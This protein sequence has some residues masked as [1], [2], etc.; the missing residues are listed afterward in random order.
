M[1]C[2]QPSLK[3]L[4]RVKMNDSNKNVWGDKPHMFMESYRHEYLI[5]T[6][7]LGQTG[8]C[9]TTAIYDKD[10]CLCH[11]LFYT[12][13]EEDASYKHQVLLKWLESNIHAI[14]AVGLPRFLEAE[15][16]MGLLQEDLAQL[17]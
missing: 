11:E 13:E 6:V 1:R 12:L 7:W 16:E 15:S 10:E 2:V 8:R 17:Q 5:K 4:K 14:R 9:F 3:S